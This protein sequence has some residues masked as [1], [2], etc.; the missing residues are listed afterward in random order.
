M[1]VKRLRTDYG[2]QVTE[3]GSLT[4]YS[5]KLRFK[6]ITYEPEMPYI[7]VQY[8]DGYCT[9]SFEVIDRVYA[10]KVWE[11]L[12]TLCYNVAKAKLENKYGWVKNK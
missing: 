6:G 3:V 8:C 5:A 1:N 11:V 2:Y 9:I 4:I 10:E 12:G 7:N